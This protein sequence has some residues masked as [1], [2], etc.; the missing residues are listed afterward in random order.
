M[1]ISWSFGWVTKIARNRRFQHQAASFHIW[2][3]LLK[4]LQNM[5][6][7]WSFSHQIYG[8]FLYLL[9][10]TSL[11]SPSQKANSPKTPLKGLLPTKKIEAPS[12][13]PKKKMWHRPK[14]RSWFQIF[15]MF[16]LNLGEMIQLHEHIFQ[17]GSFNHHLV[18]ANIGI[19][20]C[21]PALVLGESTSKNE[22]FV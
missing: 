1:F 20:P 15:S 6:H 11:S 12:F 18:K 13:S 4:P 8:G 19:Q 14:T 7:P 21:D 22:P 2:K 3:H 10:T 16:S 17:T 9:E 5:R